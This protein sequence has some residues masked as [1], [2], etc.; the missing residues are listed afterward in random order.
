MIKSKSRISNF[1]IDFQEIQELVWTLTLPLLYLEFDKPD[2]IDQEDEV[3][4]EVTKQRG[5]DEWPPAPGVCEGP[6]HQR[7][8]EPGGALQHPVI[9]L[10]LAHKLLGLNLN[11][12]AVNQKE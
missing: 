6:R 11:H 12:N 1:G 7:E 5:E 10:Q 8:D 2:R 9:R 3:E 4:H